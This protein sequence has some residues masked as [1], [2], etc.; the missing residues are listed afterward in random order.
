MHLLC[1]AQCG[2]YFRSLHDSE[3]TYTCT[4]STVRWHLWLCGMCRST[5]A[6]AITYTIA[7][8]LSTRCSTVAAALTN[9]LPAW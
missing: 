7:Y 2:P 4:Y 1:P 3:Y 6:T 5:I 8:S 9:T